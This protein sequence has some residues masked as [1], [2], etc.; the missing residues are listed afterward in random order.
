M[1]SKIKVLL[2]FKYIFRT[3][4]FSPPCT[5][6]AAPPTPCSSSARPAQPTIPTV[7]EKPTPRPHPTPPPMLMVSCPCHLYI[8]LRRS[9]L[10]HRPRLQQN[11]PKLWRNR[12]KPWRIRP[13]LR[14][15]HPKLWGIRP[16]RRTTP[17]LPRPH[18]QRRTLPTACR[19]SGACSF[20]P[21]P[22]MSFRTCS[23]A[24]LRRASWSHPLPPASTLTDPE[25]T[26][27]I[28]TTPAA[29]ANPAHHAPL[30][31]TPPTNGRGLGG[32]TPSRG[33]TPRRTA[34]HTQGR[35][36]TPTTSPSPHPEHL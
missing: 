15:N 6:P 5:T 26:T 16:R 3:E 2:I 29:A 36:Y 27:P 35:T 10:R 17:L 1:D 25:G 9:R 22:S 21:P 32:R 20:V 33:N 18:R 4:E 31:S 19:T 34:Q 13:H 28:N 30:S 8:R 14:L 12:L 24:P 23:P 7:T 11:H